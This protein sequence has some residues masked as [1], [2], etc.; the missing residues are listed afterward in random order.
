M[1]MEWLLVAV[2]CAGILAGCSDAPDGDRSGGGSAGPVAAEQVDADA[3]KRAVI[4][5]IASDHN[6][7]VGDVTRFE[8]SVTNLG[9]QT[10]NTKAAY[11]VIGSFSVD[12]STPSNVYE[13]AN[14]R[15]SAN[16]CLVA[17]DHCQGTHFRH[18]VTFDVAARFMSALD[19]SV[20]LT[21]EGPVVVDKRQ[22]S[23]ASTTDVANAP[24][25]PSGVPL[26]PHDLVP[27][28]SAASP[29]VIA[30]TPPAYPPQA[31]RLHHE[32]TVVLSLS[33]NTVGVPESVVIDESSGFRELDKAAES[34][35]RTWRFRP[36]TQGSHA[37]AGTIR[38]PVTFSLNAAGSSEAAP[39]SPA[40]AGPP[41]ADPAGSGPSFDCAKASTPAENAICTSPDLTVLDRRMGDAYR[42]RL[43]AQPGSADILRQQQRAFIKD[44]DARCNGYVRCIKGMLSSRLD[45]LQ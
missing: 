9:A 26:Q 3:L 8:A 14:Q 30:R 17:P 19:G 23:S 35:A 12:A 20:K 27:L 37:V 31:V 21:V 6:F 44:R 22:P 13:A 1:R 5:Q 38:I 2:T 34:A 33:I 36:G 40:F 41:R 25:A 39:S 42:A 18:E 29:S 28:G 32:G 15:V 43:V 7:S 10:G 24:S 4:S 45:E 16:I 11:R